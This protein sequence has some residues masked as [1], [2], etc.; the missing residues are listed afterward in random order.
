MLKYDYTEN[1]IV[2]CRE[3]MTE[4]EARLAL[5]AL[6]SEG[7]EATIDNEIFSRIY[8]IGTSDLGVLRLMVRRRDL[9]K[10]LD[11]VNTLNF[12]SY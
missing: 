4:V 7:I 10:A 8:P 1:E 12:D 9:G 11:I 3:F 2:L 5:A 6:E